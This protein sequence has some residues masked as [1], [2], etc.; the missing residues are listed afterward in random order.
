MDSTRRTS[1]ATVLGA[2]LVMA[3]ACG[4][5]P[6]AP[7]SS[8]APAPVASEAPSLIAPVASSAPVAPP[9][10]PAEPTLPRGVSVIARFDQ[11]DEVQVFPAPGGATV[12]AF[13][14]AT[15]RSRGA[16]VRSTNI[17]PAPELEGLLAPL[18]PE[19]KQGHL[20]TVTLLP[21]GEAVAG[22]DAGESVPARQCHVL[23]RRGGQ[24]LLLASL[25]AHENGCGP[26]LPAREGALAVVSSGDLAPASLLALGGA[27]GPRERPLAT[28]PKGS[29]IRCRLWTSVVL[30]A[31]AFDSGEVVTVGVPC[32]A[33]QLMIERFAK[34][35]TRSATATFGDIMLDFPTEVHILSPD[36]IAISR[37]VGN[38]ELVDVR[39]RFDR[40]AW[41]VEKRTTAAAAPRLPTLKPLDAPYFESSSWAIGDS[42]YVLL[43]PE[44]NPSQKNA[45]FA[46]PQLLVGTSPM[47]VAV[48]LRSPRAQP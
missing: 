14:L 23:R 28:T 10:A 44:D 25:G 46:S 9:P 27:P 32:E 3:L 19:V 24:W 36:E 11:S 15:R 1:V 21:D 47:T 39:L 42:A 37:G 35:A 48:D 26:V 31:R 33:P 7:P 43:I 22:F 30:A 18:P 40:R 5:P 12:V 29:K 20:F 13:D 8:P 38:L 34:G 17:S 16:S 45:S 2:S 41:K 4:A 6:P